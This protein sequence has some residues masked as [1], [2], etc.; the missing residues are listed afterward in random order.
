MGARLPGWVPV[1]CIRRF[2]ARLEQLNL[3]LHN[4]ERERITHE[5]FY[6]FGGTTEHRRKYEAA[7]E[8]YNA[9]RYWWMPAKKLKPDPRE[10]LQSKDFFPGD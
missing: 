7:I 10:L 3:I 2:L 1:M 8:Q 5:R 4:A 6:L 9:L